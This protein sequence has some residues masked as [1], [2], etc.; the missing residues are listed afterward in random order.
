MGVLHTAQEGDTLERLET[1]HGTPVQEI[2]EFPGNKFD[3]TQ[4][5]ELKVG[6]QI[7]VPN[8]RNPVVWESPGPVVIAGMGRKSPGLYSGALVNIGTGYFVW[9]VAPPIILTTEFWS[10]H[11]GIDIDT[12]YR[13][14][15]FA[16]DS[17]TV[18]FSGWDNTGFGY[19]V[20]IDHGNGYW[21]Y[22]G[23]NEANLVSVGQGV[24]IG[25]QIAESGNTGISTGDHLDFR[26][27]VEGGAYLNPLDFLP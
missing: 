26:I 5:P 16:A 21:T 11:P 6:Q 7:I 24:V 14:P 1:L 9:P 2:L 3:L 22:Y 17:G 18:I 12:Y 4:A 25:Q 19:L 23:H 13:Q 27:R 10:A 8:G 20:I 15:I